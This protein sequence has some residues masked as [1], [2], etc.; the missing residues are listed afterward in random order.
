[1]EI[2]Q[3]VRARG[4]HWYVRDERPYAACRLVTLTAA[5]GLNPV[6][7]RAPA[8]CRLLAPFDDIAPAATVSRP[9]RVGRRRWRRAC[10][11]LIAS[12]ADGALVAA[13]GARFDVLPY[14]LQPAIAL[15]RGAAT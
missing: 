13:A 10:R 8:S 5:L 15:L 14:Q 11:A 6:A 1:M 3:L 12:S 4:R 7:G 2:L 9:R